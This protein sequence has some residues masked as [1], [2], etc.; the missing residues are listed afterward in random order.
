MLTMG[1][2][3]KTMPGFSLGPVPGLPKFGTWGSS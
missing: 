1:S 2:M 3:Q